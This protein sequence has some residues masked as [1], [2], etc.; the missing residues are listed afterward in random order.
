VYRTQISSGKISLSF[1][2]FSL[3]VRVWVETA[4]AEITQQYQ[5]EAAD[6]V[7]ASQRVVPSLHIPLCFPDTEQP[8]ARLV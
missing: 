4:I 3:W 6:T 5:W 1:P 2:S 8:S 7:S